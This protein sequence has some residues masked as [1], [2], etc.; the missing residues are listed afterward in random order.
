M[1][2]TKKIRME[3]RRRTGTKTMTKMA[4]MG[5]A[6]RPQMERQPPTRKPVRE[7]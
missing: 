6:R 5:K 1:G 3:T 2:K 4:L 7:R